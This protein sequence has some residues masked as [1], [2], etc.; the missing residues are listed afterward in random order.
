LPADIPP[1]I[2]VRNGIKRYYA[3]TNHTEV[4]IA[5]RKIA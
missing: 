3:T 5:P 1:K 4:L 2:S